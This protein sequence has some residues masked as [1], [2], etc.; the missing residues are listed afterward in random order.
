MAR[1]LRI[2]LSSLTATTE[3]VPDAYR[4]FGGRGLT[5]S[6]LD[7]EVPPTCDP[8]GLENKLI[9]APGLMG[10]TTA[11]CSGRMSVGAKSPMT[12]GAK[13]SNTGG[14]MA[15]KLARL[16]FKAVI[17]E[18]KA[19]EPTMVKIDKTGVSFSSAAPLAG[20]GCYA[21]IEKL[22]SEYGENACFGC[23][24]PAGDMKLTAASII[25]TTPDFHIRVAARGG[26]GAV[27]GSKN[28]KAV[29]V[30]DAGSNL[31]EVKDPQKLKEN[32]AALSKGVLGTHFL[33]G[34]RHL[35]TPQIVMI[36][37]TAGALPTKN[38]SMG[39]FEKA[40]S[41]SGE[42]ME[43]MLK[44]RE[45]SQSVHACM[46]GCIISC[47]NVY[48]DEKG[49][50][51]VASIEYETIALV[52]SN[53]MIGDLDMVARI[54][55]AC[56]DAGVDTMDVGS[57]LAVAMEGGLLPWGDA[58]G[59]LKLVKEINAGTENGRMIGSGAKVT[60]DKLGVKRV[61]Q[62]KGQALS[63]YDPRILKGTGVTFATSP[64]GADHTAGI[65][66]PGPHH[67]EYSPVQPTGQA[68]ES[69]FMQ[70]WMA[71]IDTFGYCMMIGMTFMEEKAKKLHL[72]M[73][74]ALSAVTGETYPESYVTDL[75][76]EVLAIERKFNKAAGLTKEDD[77]LPKFFTEEKFGPGQFVFDV[78]PEEIDTVH[79]Q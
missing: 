43:E 59:A 33:E 15:Q 78:S 69:Q 5:A 67:P 9:W 21:M 51:I 25:F 29:V 14:A 63:A 76:A 32:N 17:F 46:K 64:Q 10:G 2:N 52:G 7:R 37:Q 44:K 35:G 20:L 38:F 11:P 57:A 34:L 58:E 75:G 30:D 72:N 28:M 31:L 26:L 18:G 66:L 54:N 3:A 39:Q 73:I 53:C 8:L 40:E 77:R 62:V 49:K 47:S 45:N 50:F 61:P 70:Q 6:I 74:G 60:G 13:E 36:T 4:K 41:L 27:M 79:K 48:T 22:K 65:V 71:A 55:A 12:K 16:G 19:K 56:N 1:L 23:I 68:P 24:G 42:Y